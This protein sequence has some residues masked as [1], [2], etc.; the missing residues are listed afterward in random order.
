MVQAAIEA[1]RLQLGDI[2]SGAGGHEQLAA[3]T[4]AADSIVLD[5]VGGSIPERGMPVILGN[6]MAFV[7]SNYVAPKG[8]NF[9]RYS[10]DYHIL[11]NY[12]HV[13]QE[14]GEDRAMATMPQYARD[15]VRHYL[16]SPAS[17]G[18]FA[19]LKSQI[20]HMDQR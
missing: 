9:A 16:S 17:D 4:V 2:V 11:R 18:T 13:L 7:I 12:L 10:I 15:I 3:A 8:I 14:W 5:M 1:K 20:Q 6:V 19:K